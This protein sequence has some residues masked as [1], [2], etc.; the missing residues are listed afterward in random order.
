MYRLKQR[1]REVKRG[2]RRGGKGHKKKGGRYIRIG[3]QKAGKLK[4]VMGSGMRRKS[5]GKSKLEKNN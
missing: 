3:V 4:K 5:G 2:K 1:K